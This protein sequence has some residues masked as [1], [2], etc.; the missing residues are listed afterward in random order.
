MALSFSALVSLIQDRFRKPNIGQKIVAADSEDVA[1]AIANFVTQD[2]ASLP[3]YAKP[4]AT[5]NAI[6]YLSNAVQ[7]TDSKL[8]HF[9][10][11]GGGARLDGAWMLGANAITKTELFQPTAHASNRYETLVTIPKGSYGKVTLEIRVRAIGN[12]AGIIHKIYTFDANTSSGATSTVLVAD[13]DIA[14]K[15][16]VDDPNW[17]GANIIVPIYE[18]AA[19]NTTKLYV[20]EVAIA[21]NTTYITPLLAFSQILSNVTT[22]ARTAGNTNASVGGSTQMSVTSDSS[23]IKLVNDVTTPAA[24]QA[25]STNA[26]GTRGWYNIPQDF[27]IIA[28]SVAVSSLAN[29]TTKTTIANLTGPGAL[30]TTNMVEFRAVGT[31]TQNSGSGANFTF[32]SEIVTNA[33][34]SNLPLPTKLIINQS[35]ESV[36]TFE[37][38]AFREGSAI[39]V[40]AF[41]KAVCDANTAGNA[42]EAIVK[43]FSIASA[44]TITAMRMNITF[45]YAHAN[46]SIQR[47]IAWVRM[48]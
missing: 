46:I 40:L 22:T 10:G 18:K 23:G 8:S 2:G 32:E 29:S 20:V 4:N 27:D 38:W 28:S 35:G 39:T 45:G 6:P 9:G 7:L 36:F 16:Y 26:A 19:A 1:A 44:S 42:P 33:G 34:T 11:L 41:F 14:T 15:I 48:I 12:S 13:G 21:A 43:R 24:L 37:V 47:R 31:F 30:S 3:P 17:A 5:T 25:Y